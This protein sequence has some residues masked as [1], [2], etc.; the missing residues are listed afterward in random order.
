M[1]TEESNDMQLSGAECVNPYSEDV[2]KGV[3]VE[4]MFDSIAPAYDF[5]NT[6]MTFGLHKS[7]RSRAISYATK[8]LAKDAPLSI[9][10]LATG[11][12]DLAF[13]LHSR[14]PNAIIT[15]VDL[16]E[17]MLQVA[18]RKLANMTD[19]AK[20][21]ISFR[22]GDCLDLEGV[23]DNSQDLI[24]IAYGVR[25]FEH[26]RQGMKEMARVLKPGG[27][28]CIIELSQPRTP[29]LR[30]LY[31]LY[32]HH[33]I[34]FIGKMVSHDTRAYSYLPESIAAA[35]QRGKL[36]RIMKDCGF[37]NPDWRSMTFGSVT[38]Y[39]ASK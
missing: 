39:T 6:A 27:V 38:Y 19:A 36:T 32:S 10:D 13:H 23:G 5:M 3:Q 12:G 7:W 37:L 34:P 31:N 21:K 28:I 33:I 25:N 4:Q 16:S 1:K 8:K 35:P 9:L 29:H 15:G 14:F 26:L 2:A 24:T 20:D 22:Q 30:F 17:G 18:E 11:T